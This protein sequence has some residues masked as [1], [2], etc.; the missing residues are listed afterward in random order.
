[1]LTS[2]KLVGFLVKKHEVVILVNIIKGWLYVIT[3][4]VLVFYLVFAALRRVKESEDR[5]RETNANL[6]I[7]VQE[8]SNELYLSNVKLEETNTVLEEE[9]NE[10]E[11]VEKQLFSLNRNLETRVSERT[12]QL[13]ELNGVLEETNAELEETNASLEDE[14][15]QR[16]HVQ[17][18]LNESEKQFRRAIEDAPIPIILLA[19]DGEILVINKTWTDISGYAL[20]DIPTIEYRP[21]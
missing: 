3:T 10:R 7:K 1:M 21:H 8:R 15:K 17:K 4:A 5:V 12:Y 18:A 6:E 19:E 2:D 16:I 9:I 20:S 13:E 14:I 11:K